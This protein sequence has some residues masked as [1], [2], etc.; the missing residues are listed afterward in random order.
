MTIPESPGM[1]FVDGLVA[2]KAEPTS[3]WEIEQE[4][5]VMLGR[6]YRTP[7]PTDYMLCV[8]NTGTKTI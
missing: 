5:Y 1:V 6:Y 8:T 2:V 4:G 3:P 7:V